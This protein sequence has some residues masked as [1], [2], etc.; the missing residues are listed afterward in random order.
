[1]DFG[2]DVKI[3]CLL[4]QNKSDLINNEHP[5]NYQ[6]KKYLDEFSKTN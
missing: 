2:S 6:T 1:M 5:E 3:P 4:V